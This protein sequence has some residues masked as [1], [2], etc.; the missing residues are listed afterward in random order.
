MRYQRSSAQ[1]HL[2]DTRVKAAVASSGQRPTST[3][4]LQPRS[5]LLVPTPLLTRIPP[6][7]LRCDQLPRAARCA[8]T[9]WNCEKCEKEKKTEMML[10]VRSMDFFPSSRSVRDSADSTWKWDFNRI[11]KIS[12]K[13]YHTVLR[14]NRGFEKGPLNS[15]AGPHVARHQQRLQA[16]RVARQRRDLRRGSHLPRRT[17][18]VEEKLR[19]VNRG[20][21]T[22]NADGRWTTPK[23]SRRTCSPRCGLQFCGAKSAGVAKSSPPTRNPCQSD[24][25]P[26]ASLYAA[27]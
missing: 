17:H 7:E 9:G 26:C 2:A 25:Q 16:I 19:I 10:M 1:L 20:L 3:F 11:L 13:G 27:S 15:Q 14:F 22:E 6:L 4:N 23:L 5:R 21:A 12:E 18:T 8:R 24:S